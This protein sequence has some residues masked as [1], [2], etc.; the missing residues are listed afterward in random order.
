ML[1]L[2][3]LWHR[4]VALDAAVLTAAIR[5]TLCWIPAHRSTRQPVAEHVV[6]PVHTA[7][8]VTVPLV[9]RVAW[10]AADNNITTPTTPIM[11]TD[12][13]RPRP[14]PRSRPGTGVGAVALAGTLRSILTAAPLLGELDLLA[15]LPGVPQ[16]DVA[17]VTALARL[18]LHLLL[19]LVPLVVGVRDVMPLRRPAPRPLVADV[20]NAGT[21][22]TRGAR[23][24]M[25]T[26]P[27]L[28]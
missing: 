22:G 19:L 28:P 27:A 16:L 13:S 24:T 23:V 4:A 11:Q 15:L 2:V 20:S 17:A 18:A 26:V 12:R 10:M 3:L 9:H 6:A 1:V 25:E 5:C 8:T 21:G 14:R 7:L